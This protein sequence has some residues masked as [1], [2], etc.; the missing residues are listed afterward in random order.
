ME[1]D[2]NSD[3][4]AIDEEPYDMDLTDT[5]IEKRLVARSAQL[6]DQLKRLRS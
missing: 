5:E 4:E 3:S 6:A 1:D 2:P